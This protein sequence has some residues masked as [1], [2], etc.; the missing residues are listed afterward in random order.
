MDLPTQ[1]AADMKSALKAGDKTRLS[2]IRMLLSDIKTIDLNPANPTPEQVVEAYARKLRKSRDEYQKI[3]Q[4][5]T[6][7][8]LS[9]EL[10][11]VNAYL[12]KRAT[13]EQTAALVDAFLA[14][15]T[16]THKQFGQAMGAFL[17]QHGNTVDAAAVSQILKQKLPAE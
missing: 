1:L 2:V 9:A 6:V 11:I 14:S 5:D 3:G 17:K 12:P 7:A 16:Y 13:P 4:T 15:K 10:E 8:T